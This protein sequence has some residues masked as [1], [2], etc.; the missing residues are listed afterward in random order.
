MLTLRPSPHIPTR[1]RIYDGEFHICSIDNDAADAIRP[2]LPDPDLP[3]GVFREPGTDR[4][5]ARGENAPES[6]T[7]HYTEDGDPA[8]Y[9]PYPERIYEWRPDPEPATETIPWHEAKDRTMPDGDRI[10][11][12]ANDAYGPNVV[13]ARGERICGE[14]VEVLAR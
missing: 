2:Y 1:T 5:L 13:P 6:G 7:L 8:I 4:L 9:N 10:L 12:V 3:P 14:T 11:Y